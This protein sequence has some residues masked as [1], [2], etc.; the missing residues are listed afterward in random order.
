MNA[1][2]RNEALMSRLR[3]GAE[4]GALTF[5]RFME[6]CLYDPED[7]FYAGPSAE[8]GRGGH[9]FTSVQVSH[10]FG[11]MLAQQILEIWDRLGRPVPFTLV[12]QGAH[13]GR[14]A[15]DILKWL[16]DFAPAL[17]DAAECVLVEPF[18][19]WRGRQTGT[20]AR[21]GLSGKMRHVA[22][23]DAM[24]TAAGAG[25]L[26]CNELLDAFPVPRVRFRGG[27]WREIAVAWDGSGFV[28]ADG[29][30]LT[31]GLRESLAALPL[32]P[33]EGYATE[34]H[35]GL[36]PWIARAA[37]IFER[38]AVLVFDYGLA[39][40]VYYAPERCEGTIRAF[41]HHRVQQDLLARPGGQDLTAHV[42]W[43]VL[44]AAAHSAGFAF[45]GIADHHRFAV[46]LLADDLLRL[47][48]GQ[49]AP[50]DPALLR[51][52]Q[53]LAHPEMLG[54]SFAAAGFAKG[55][56]RDTPPAGFRHA[57]FFL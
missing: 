13:D 50:P 51:A 30:L 12:E 9:F 4:T 14:L 24:E 44:A 33:I 17:F 49:S 40:D 45:L 23:L 34:I 20:L 37:R 53:T 56:P 15:A 28:E 29:P 57:R 36:A 21:E 55:L 52:W 18:V 2:P 48:T 54:R 43:T 10:L 6:M 32:P 25:I 47:E 3:A 39:Q 5:R 7:G 8:L 19:H 11:Q 26:Y 1:T 38:G 46:G 27:A 42:N 35:D 16:R 41:F 31:P 22:D